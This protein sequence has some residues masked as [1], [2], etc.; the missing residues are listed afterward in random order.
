MTMPVWLR[1]CLLAS[2][3][4]V[5]LAPGSAASEPVVIIDR[6]QVNI[7]TDAT[8]QSPRVAVLEA[9]VEV[10]EIRRH[11]QWLQIRMLDGN[12]GWVHSELVRQR[13]VVIGNGVR[14]RSGP[15]TT[16]DAVTMLYDGQEL[17]K[18]SQQDGWMKV[19]LSDGR[20]GW[21]HQRFARRK[22]GDDVRASLPKGLAQLPDPSAVED[23]PAAPEVRSQFIERAE[24]SVAAQVETTDTAEPSAIEIDLE[25]E[26]L[27]NPYAEG[28]QQ[29][30]GGDHRTA[31]ERFEEVLAKDPDHLNALFHAAQAHT[32]MREYDE[33]LVKLYRA[34]EKSGGRKDIY[35]TLGEVY[36]RQAMLDSARKYETLFAGGVID[37]GLPIEP[38]EVPEPVGSSTP[39]EL[40][41]LLLAI[42]GSGFAVIVAVVA[43]MRLR[44]GEAKGAP[45]GGKA[46]KKEK[47]KSGKFARALEHEGD[48]VSQGKATEGEEE[49]LDRQID[50]KWRELKQSAQL[51]GPGAE[52]QGDDEE[53]TLDRI[54]DNVEALRKALDLQDDRA[55]IYAEIVRL[56]N[57]KIES[58]SE[59]VRLL[60]R[61]R[62]GR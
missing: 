38:V 18:I 13:F 14:V 24:E 54:L 16:D 12:I 26:L 30:A 7:R 28:L 52:R 40:P 1:Y 25:Q 51:F 10:E 17:G 4:A 48:E 55:R 57:M 9:G 35:L 29:E 42:A 34:L 31:L 39:D 11:G 22:T 49:T 33:A 20:T 8:T 27:R 46:A 36:R 6:K 45:G 47:Q 3:P 43:W 53:G 61:N 59:E 19:S 50:D 60:R 62:K 44:G 5:C 37:I 41:W 56:Q 23:P 58:M 2:V 32:R 21:I 15:S